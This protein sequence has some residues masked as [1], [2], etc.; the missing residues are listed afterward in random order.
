V[1]TISCSANADA[2]AVSAAKDAHVN[3]FAAAHKHACSQKN[4]PKWNGSIVSDWEKGAAFAVAKVS[5]AR[6]C[7]RH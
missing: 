6:P 3:A 7:E 2:Q 5:I 1:N 4:D